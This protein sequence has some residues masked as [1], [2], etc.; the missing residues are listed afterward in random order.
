M[1]DVIDHGSA[2][3]AVATI[4]EAAWELSFGIYLIVKGFRPSPIL[5]ELDSGPAARAAGA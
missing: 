3:Q 5:A 4:P 1:F 2:V